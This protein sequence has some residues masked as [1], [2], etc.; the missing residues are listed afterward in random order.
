MQRDDKSKFLLFIEPTLEQKASIPMDDEYIT[1]LRMAMN[2][3]K[4]GASN[5][6]EPGVPEPVFREGSRYKGVHTNCDGIQS[7]NYD[8]LLPNGMVT[9][10]L[11]I[12]YMRFYR[13]AIPTSDWDKL[14]E[15]QRYYG[16]ARD[17]QPDNL[18]RIN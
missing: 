6:D 14:T 5:Y 18:R 4:L 9:N 3:A 17:V 11:C 16:R 15:L 1:L 10:S 13:L 7:S 8:L 2:D 12:H